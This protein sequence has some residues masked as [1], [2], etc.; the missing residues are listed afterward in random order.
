MFTNDPI[1]S[2]LVKSAKQAATLG[3]PGAVALTK[4]DVKALYDL[5]LL[6]KVLKQDKQPTIRPP[7]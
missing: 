7:A 1:A 6:N 4:A 3:L 2:S 5:K